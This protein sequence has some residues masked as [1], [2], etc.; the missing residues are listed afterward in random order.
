M[1]NRVQRAVMT[2]VYNKA[3]DKNGTCL[4]RPID[5]LQSIPYGVRFDREELPAYL[6]SLEIDDY[7]EV[8]ETDKKGDKYYCFTLH[9]NGYAFIRQLKSEKRAVIF[10]IV[11][12]VAGACLSFAIGALLKHLFS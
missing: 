3:A 5:L 9:Q 11:L 12:T 2:A 10:K 7:F 4:I 8:I 6:R 1:I